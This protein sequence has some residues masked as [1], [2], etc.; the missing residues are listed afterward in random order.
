MTLQKT[1]CSRVG[2]AVR[3]RE[4]S[5]DPAARLTPGLE[6]KAQTVA[7]NHTL[8][9]NG[10][11]SSRSQNLP[12]LIAKVP[13]EQPFPRSASCFAVADQAGRKDQSVVSSQDVMAIEQGRQ[14]CEPM[15]CDSAA[16]P[17]NDHESRLFARLCRFLR[18]QFVGEVKI[19]LGGQHARYSSCFEVRSWGAIGI[20]VDS[21]IK[22]DTRA[23]L[24]LLAGLSHPVQAHQ[25]TRNGEA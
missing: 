22:K 21:K 6:D 10:L 11:A 9:G 2:I 7:D 16:N 18:D 5:N 13:Q 19:K 17:I 25:A 23:T 1:E 3:F 24:D 12:C 15:M 8:S 14:L 20:Q 4:W